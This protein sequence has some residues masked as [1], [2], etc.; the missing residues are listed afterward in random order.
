MSAPPV[1]GFWSYL[2]DARGNW[3]AVLV[4]P[5]LHAN[6]LPE[7]F[8]MRKRNVERQTRETLKDPHFPRARENA[9]DARILT[10]T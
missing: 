2:G 1:T 5:C 7:R 10:M 9:I 4:N 3:R 6:I 8:D